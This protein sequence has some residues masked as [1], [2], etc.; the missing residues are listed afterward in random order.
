MTNT[1]HRA[2]ELAFIDAIRRTHDLAVKGLAG[3]PVPREKIREAE[4]DFRAARDAMW[5]AKREGAIE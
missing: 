4:A 2:L 5:T 3:S 1:D